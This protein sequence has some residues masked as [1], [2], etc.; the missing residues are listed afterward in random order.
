MGFAVE[1]RLKQEGTSLRG[2]GKRDE[3]V[4]RLSM[5]KKISRL[6]RKALDS[7][8]KKK[9]GY[10]AGNLIYIRYIKNNLNNSRFGVVVSFAAEQPKKGRAVLR[11][12][13]KRRILEISRQITKNIGTGLDVVFFVKIK[14]RQA[15]KFAELKEDILYVLYRSHRS[16]SIL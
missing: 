12:L 4:L 6:D 2:A 1:W 16:R 9:T 3:S 13:T 11:N 14:N 8:F 15:P 5:L 7:F 10:T